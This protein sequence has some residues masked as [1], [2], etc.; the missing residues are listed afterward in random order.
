MRRS[1]GVERLPICTKDFC[2]GGMVS[3]VGVGV[4]AEEVVDRVMGRKRRN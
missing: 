3:S 2:D 1:S 4:C